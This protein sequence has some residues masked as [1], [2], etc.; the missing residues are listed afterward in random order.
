MEVDEIKN[1]CKIPAIVENA[2]SNGICEQI[3]RYYESQ[4]SEFV[5]GMNREDSLGADAD[6]AKLP[7]NYT[8]NCMVLRNL[9][10]IQD[11]CEYFQAR[12][13]FEHLRSA[14]LC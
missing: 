8:T 1:A 5:L 11:N 4:S 7:P 9:C 6:K 3:C 2:T 13:I 10:S 12:G 14:R